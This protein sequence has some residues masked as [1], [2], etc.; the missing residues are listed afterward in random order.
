VAIVAVFD[1]LRGAIAGVD[2]AHRE[3][4]LGPGRDERAR[5]LKTNS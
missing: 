1:V 2:A 5:G 3:R 4:D